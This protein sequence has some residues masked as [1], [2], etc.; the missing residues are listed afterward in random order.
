M[1]DTCRITPAGLRT[2]LEA[3][4][5]KPSRKSDLAIV[6]RCALSRWQALGRYLDDDRLEIDNN[7]AERALRG[8]ALGRKNW[9]FA[10][11]DKGGER[12]AAIYSLIEAAKLNGVDPEAWLRNTISRIADHPRTLALELP[13]CLILTRAGTD[14]REGFPSC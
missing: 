14:S 8:V 2:W 5:P 13:R 11:S 4:L 7:A 6:V 12:A 1:T 10:G 9:L 3:T